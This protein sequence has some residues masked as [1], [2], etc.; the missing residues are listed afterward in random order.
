MTVSELIKELQRVD[1]NRK[2]VLQKDSEGNGYSPLY[3]IWE[4]AYLAETDWSGE[5]YLET[6]SDND[7]K[8]GY[9]EEDVREDGEKAVFLSP[10][11]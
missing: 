10:I 6:L 5:A 8:Q 3:N 11:N 9:T 7:K 2:V 4:G 1:G